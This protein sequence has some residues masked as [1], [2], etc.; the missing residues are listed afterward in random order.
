MLV[1]L[2]ENPPPSG[3]LLTSG[4]LRTLTDYKIDD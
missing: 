2:A 1:P 4:N 3:A